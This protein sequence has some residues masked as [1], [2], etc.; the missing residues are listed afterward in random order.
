MLSQLNVRCKYC[1]PH[2]SW[3]CVWWRARSETRVLL[4]GVQ[5]TIIC[6]AISYPP[7]KLS[8]WE[9]WLSLSLCLMQWGIPH[10]LPTSVTGS[11]SA[12]FPRSSYS[13]STQR[14]WLP[15]TPEPRASLA[16]PKLPNSMAPQSLQMVPSLLVSAPRCSRRSGPESTQP[17]RV[18]KGLTLDPK[19]ELLISVDLL[20]RPWWG[21]SPQKLGTQRPPLSSP[22]ERAWDISVT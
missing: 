18:P 21:C 17:W 19:V 14:C 7:V 2:T 6:C 5:S 10:Q 22:G 9:A 15:M 12:Y 13:P 11:V 1:W 20:F 16:A 4:T 3:G 8:L